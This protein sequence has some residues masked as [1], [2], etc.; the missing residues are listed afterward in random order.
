MKNVTVQISSLEFQG[1]E[2]KYSLLNYFLITRL[3]E[4]SNNRNKLRLKY[5][6]G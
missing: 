2:K 5:W 1:S 4:R 3:P 6:T